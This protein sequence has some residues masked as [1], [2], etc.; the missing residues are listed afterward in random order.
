MTEGGYALL[1]R[2]RDNSIR[3]LFKPPL[4][5]LCKDFA[6]RCAQFLSDSRK[7]SLRLDDES[8]SAGIAATNS[9]PLSGIDTGEVFKVSGCP[10]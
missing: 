9:H 7:D 8:Q 2:F 1:H 3:N 4:L 6:V 5:F 10:T